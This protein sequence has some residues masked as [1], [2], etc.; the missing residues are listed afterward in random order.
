MPKSTYPLGLVVLIGILA[1]GYA[2]VPGDLAA[3]AHGGTGQIAGT[4]YDSSGALV[5]SANV[6]A[7]NRDTGLIRAT[8][9]NDAGE[10]R[11]FLLPPGPYTVVVKVTG[12]K[13]AQSD[14]VVTVGATVTVN[15]TLEV[16][17]ITETVE[18]TAS[19]LISTTRPEA[20]ALINL[21]SISELPING[22]RFH[23]FVQLAPTVQTEPRRNYISFVGQR[24][25][26]ANISIDGADYNN[27][28]FG[29]MRGGERANNAFSIPQE[30]IREFQVVPH[31]YS[32]EFGRSSGGFLN[33]VTK[34][35]TNEWHATAFG[36]LRHKELSKRDPFLRAT[37][38]SQTQFGGSV[39]GPIRQDKSFVFFAIE[40][41]IN[42]NPRFVTFRL[43]DTFT[44][45]AATQEAFDFY[46][47]HETPFTQTNDA[48]S[49]LGRWD[50]NFTD[51]HRLAVRYHQSE[52]TA[53]NASAT[54]DDIRP[55][56]NFAM[57][58]N[59]TEGSKTKTILGHF[60]SYF[61]PTLINELRA[62][63]S[64]EDRP[65]TANSCGE[66]IFNRVQCTSGTETANLNTTVGIIGTRNFLPTT[67]FDTRLQIADNVT[68]NIGRHSLKMGGE[69][70][71][72]FIDQLFGF[73]QFGVFSVSG[74]AVATV[75]GIVSFDPAAV[76]A[77]H[78]FNSTA[79]TYNVNIG[80][81]E[82]S[83]SMYEV[84]AF[85]TD[86]W[87]I[88]PRFTL[89]YGLR[90]EGYFNPE[91]DTSNTA[92]TDLV[93]NFTF[94]LGR[95]NPG[96]IPDNTDQWMPRLGIAWDPWGD[97]KTVIRANA[98]LYYART[99]MLLMAG[100]LNN[101]RT[102]A[103]D[104]SVQLPL[105]LPL[106]PVGGDSCAPNGITPIDTGDTC[107]TV[108]WQMRR[109]GINLDSFATL[110]DLLN[111]P[112][113][114]LAD[115]TA[116]ATSLGLTVDPNRGAQ[117][118]TW[119]DDYEAPRSWQWSVGL[120]REIMRGWALGGDYVYVN[121]VHLQ[122]NR[123]WNLPVPVVCDA[124]AVAAGLCTTTDLSLRPCFGVR[125]GGP[126]GSRARPISTLG[127]VQ[128]RETGGRARYHGFTIRNV[129]RRGRYQFQAYYTWSEN[130]SHD[131][132]EREAGG[133]A[134]ID[135]V[136]NLTP[137]YHYSNLDA[138]HM[139]LLNAVVELPAGFTLSGLTRFRSARPINPTSGSDGISGGLVLG[140]HDLFGVDR[141]MAA[142]GVPFK[143]N[144]F[145]DQPL[146][147]ADLRIAH[148]L[149]RWLPLREGM[150]L[151]L[152]VDIFNIF[153]FDNVTY[154]STNRIYGAG[155]SST[156]GGIVAPN[157][158]FRRLRVASAC[159]DP[160]LRPT[161]NP[162]CY[163]TTN[164]PNTQSS[165]RQVQVGL[166]FQF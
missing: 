10:Y 155:I 80:N 145:R 162:G 124:A 166:R 4:V 48:I 59:G 37:L 135:N 29:G 113:L 159:Y 23:D 119:A 123:D 105:A 83:A 151:D 20:D 40:D 153:D 146:S 148:N 33:A 129:I 74:S 94:P 70:N 142:P 157:A 58:T 138:R 3:Q 125:S 6:T 84:A 149:G 32:A 133:A 34:S 61:S 69:F 16:G 117:P 39:G 47:S 158:A 5:P 65:R 160:V 35:G 55:E 53:K 56:T 64:R 103:G 132:N 86:T 102:P 131:D 87:R 150:R 75:L 7:T 26:N 72:L 31:S 88:T 141:P 36:F 46:K 106:P 98:G 82:L 147:A 42:D 49:F 12:F 136:Y 15:F 115:L 63:F 126:C 112:P 81:Q 100:P 164:V 18:V 109:A 128:V 62:Q 27:S 52:N 137:E 41:Q 13:T 51:K 17:E 134:L 2:F 28:F 143:R 54:G 11:L 96:L 44:P 99:P 9:S 21:R 139:F 163:D 165:P 71:R 91:P 111:M 108:Y 110:G 89:T 43:L 97:T 120:E 1:C 45:T 79:V 24:G 57:S 30:S 25:I 90:W 127:Q 156:T 67:A 73:N 104:L 140:S 66:G 68:W 93:R 38:S 152:T 107:N 50:H 78:R 114:T 154:G 122:F 22:R 19:E 101:F 60:T 95:V 14:V 121:T 8:T 77:D 161:G 130:F 144:S 118:L 92:L 85:F 116:I 76:P